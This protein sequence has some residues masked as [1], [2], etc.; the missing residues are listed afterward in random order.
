MRYSRH[1]T[2]TL[3]RQL[4]TFSHRQSLT[5]VSQEEIRKLTED[6]ADAAKCRDWARA[7]EKRRLR[8]ALEAQGT[9]SSGDSNNA[10]NSNSQFNFTWRKKK[11]E[12]EMEELRVNHNWLS[13]CSVCW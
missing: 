4:V 8:L 9:A 6:E 7:R 10:E 1:T 13:V 3:A 5:D 11:L 12:A 2:G